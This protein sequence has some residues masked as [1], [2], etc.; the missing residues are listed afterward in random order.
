MSTTSIFLGN[1]AKANSASQEFQGIVIE[2]ASKLCHK[3]INKVQ[4]LARVLIFSP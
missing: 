2:D 4:V 1:F 3:K